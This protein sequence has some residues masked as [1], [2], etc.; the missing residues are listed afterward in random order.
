[1]FMWV[2]PA[3]SQTTSL[4]QTYY[5]LNTYIGGV[6]MFCAECLFVA[7]TCVLWGYKRSIVVLFMISTVLYFVSGIVILKMHASST[8]VIKSPI[9]FASCFDSEESGLVIAAYSLLIL[10]E[11]Q[12]VFF[13]LYKATKSFRNWGRKN[14]LLEIL[15]QHNIFYFACGLCSSVIVILTTALLQASYGNL[16]ASAQVVF[17]ALLVTKMHLNLWESDRRCNS[18][19]VRHNRSSA[20]NN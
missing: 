5:T 18:L 8:R 11:L 16:M 2:Q 10:A 17:H 4:C 15:I 14:R 12:I 9:P 1:M 19:D 7:R 20:V 6:I 13:S 3:L